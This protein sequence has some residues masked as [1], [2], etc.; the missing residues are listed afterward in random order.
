MRL[1][2]K[3]EFDGKAR[4]IDEQAAC[5]QC[6]ARAMVY[7]DGSLCCIAEGGLSFVPEESDKDLFARRAAY[8]ARKQA[9]S[10]QA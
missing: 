7:E 3:T 1:A 2:N 6:S 8:L 5:P 9:V 4:R 10:P